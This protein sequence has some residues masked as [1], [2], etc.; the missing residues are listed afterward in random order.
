MRS[1]TI[2][3]VDTNLYIKGLS[4]PLVFRAAY[5]IIADLLLFVLLYILAGALLAVL[6]CVPVFFSWLYYLHHIQK[7]YTPAGW[8]KKRIARQLPG[9]IL[10]KQ[11]ICKST[12]HE[13]HFD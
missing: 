1:Y 4:G 10:V 2:Q 6:V 9:F 13:N 3:K 5:G 7:K 11:R 12:R 8:Q